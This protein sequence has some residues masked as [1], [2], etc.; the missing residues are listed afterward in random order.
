[1][2]IIFG[3]HELQNE[4]SNLRE[5]DAPAS[6]ETWGTIHPND[7]ALP[8]KGLY[9]LAISFTSMLHSMTLVIIK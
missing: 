2:E 3:F 1:M 9:T 6:F 7:I 5:C 4:N 8:S